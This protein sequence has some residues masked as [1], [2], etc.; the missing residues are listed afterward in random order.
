[1]DNRCVLITKYLGEMNCTISDLCRI[2]WID[3]AL[4]IRNVMRLL[5]G[6]RNDFDEVTEL[7]SL[8]RELK[9]LQASFPVE[10]DFKNTGESRTL[11]LRTRELEDRR[12]FLEK[13]KQ[14]QQEMV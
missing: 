13:Q 4:R 6:D 5:K 9:D 2:G 1:M 3:G 11:L 7:L 12:A 14:R 10:L 8:V